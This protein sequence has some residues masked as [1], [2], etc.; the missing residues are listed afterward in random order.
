MS[1]MLENDEVIHDLLGRPGPKIIQKDGVFRFSLDAVLLAD[2]VHV[3]PSTGLIMDLGTGLAPIPLLLAR[4]TNARIIG[5]EIQADVSA[6]ARK[7]VIL[8][9]LED[10][11]TIET[12]D[13]RV[14]HSRYLPSSFDI[15]TCN[16]P[17]FK[18]MDDKVSSPNQKIRIAKEE[19]LIDWDSIVLEAK[20]LLKVGGKFVFVHRANRLEEIIMSLNRKG[21]ALKRMQLVHTKPQEVATMVLIEAANH[22]KQGGLKIEES[23]YIHDE[24]GKYTEAALRIFRQEESR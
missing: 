22:G 2:F 1:H 24:A 12:D 5:I 15:V 13:I 6:I 11:I 21:F 3:N 4:K 20:R 17:F 18:Q 19:V 8:N 9:N 16:P 7:S 23:L 14:V 10:Q